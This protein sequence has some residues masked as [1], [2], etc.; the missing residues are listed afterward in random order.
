MKDFTDDYIT[1]YVSRYKGKVAAWD[2][3]NEAFEDSGNAYRKSFW[4]THLG[5]DYIE[6]AFRLAHAADPAAGLFYN[7]FSIEQDTAKLNAV[8]KMVNQFKEKGVP[9]TGLGFQMHITIHTPNSAIARA[10][11]KAAA[12]G[13]K[14]HISELDIS[15]NEYHSKNKLTTFNDSLKQVQAAKYKSIAMMYR[16]YIPKAQQFGITL[17]EFNDR[18][19]WIRSFV[20][21]VDWPTLFDDDLNKKPAYEGFVEGLTEPIEK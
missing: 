15:I 14:I 7:D 8:L 3:V 1:T 10:F 9:I 19:T 2:V 20:K 18:D 6:H 11:K 13:L 17:W 21:Q 16:Q 5:S 4:Y 12:T